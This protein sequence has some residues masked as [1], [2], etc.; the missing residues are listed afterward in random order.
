[1]IGTSSNKGGPRSVRMPSVYGARLVA[2]PELVDFIGLSV[3]LVREVSNGTAHT[4]STR[5]A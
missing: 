2:E 1:M 5:T 4:R 3:A